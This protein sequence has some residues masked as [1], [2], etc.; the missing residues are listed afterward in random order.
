MA[1]RSLSA[2]PAPNKTQPTNVVGDIPCGY[3]QLRRGIGRIF[4]VGCLGLAVVSTGCTMTSGVCRSVSKS[5]CVNDFMISYRNRAMAEKAWHCNKH[6]FCDKQHMSAFKDGFIQGYAEVASG[7]NGCVPAVAPS[8]YWGWRYQ[9][10]QGQGAVNAWF[11]GFPMGVQAA[12]EDGVGHWQTIR[13]SGY[14][15]TAAAVAPALAPAFVP[16][17]DGVANPFYSEQEFVPAPTPVDSDAD[18]EDADEMELESDESTSDDAETV[19]SHSPHDFP[20][21]SEPR[22]DASDLVSKS[23]PSEQSTVSDDPSGAV[24]IED[25]FGSDSESIG[26]LESIA[27]DAEEL[28]FSFE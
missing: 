15:P 24:E 1:I 25:V 23:A 7:G 5:D 21:V 14:M 19:F 9:S 6:R 17:N 16:S 20:V 11:A 13:P 2:K 26:D 3:R 12:E 27:T 8:E 4:A 28:P 18:S 10:A 22:N